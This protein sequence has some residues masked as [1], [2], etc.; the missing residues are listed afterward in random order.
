M[1]HFRLAMD[2]GLSTMD[3][4]G[5]KKVKRQTH[6]ITSCAIFAA[7]YQLNLLYDLETSLYLFGW[8]EISDGIYRNISHFVLNCACWPQCLYLGK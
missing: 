6:S 2:L 7:I 1:V 3:P 8:K 5:Y 4:I